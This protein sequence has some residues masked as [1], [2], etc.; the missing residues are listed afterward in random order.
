MTLAA[1]GLQV[2]HSVNGST[3]GGSLTASCCLAFM[4]N[5]YGSAAVLLVGFKQE[6]QVLHAAATVQLNEVLLW[7]GLGLG[8]G[9]T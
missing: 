5:V 6:Q 2:P 8:S 4:T 3:H 7:L 1:E 9:L